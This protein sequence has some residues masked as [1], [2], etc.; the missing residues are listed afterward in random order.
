MYIYYAD[1]QFLA[2][3]PTKIHKIAYLYATGSISDGVPQCMVL[4]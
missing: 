4:Q 1:S 2:Y 3:K